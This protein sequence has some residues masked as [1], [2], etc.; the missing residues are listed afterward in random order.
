M[1]FRKC[2]S[3]PGSPRLVCY[4]LA[5]QGR[6]Q[7]FDKRRGEPIEKKAKFTKVVPT[8]VT[9]WVS[10]ADVLANMIDFEAM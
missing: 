2:C 10:K 1:L 4:A 8:I 9:F 5:K 3:A 6:S 7:N